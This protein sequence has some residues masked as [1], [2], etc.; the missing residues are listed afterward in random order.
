MN[1]GPLIAGAS[2][3]GLAISFGSQTLVRDIVSGIFFM[4]DDAFRVGEYI[5]TGKLKGTVE[6]ISV[7]SI[8]LRHQNGQI[9]TVPFGQM[10]A[11]TN[12]S[13]DWA[14]VKFEMRLARDTDLEKARKVVKKVGLAMLED[15]EFKPELLEP[16][17]LQGVA[18]I[19][20]NA[21]VVRCKFTARPR[22]PSSIQRE[23]LRR[24]FHAFGDNGIQF[25]SPLNLQSL[26]ALAGP[27]AEPGAAPAAAAN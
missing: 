20:D 14:T 17:K 7:R 3:F 23:A 4:A 15:P 10:S 16:L 21:I 8:K 5:D 2:I 22:N 1:I 13:R 19:T 9:H 12:F 26:L 25:A 6:G 18:D 27:R 24:L 11:V